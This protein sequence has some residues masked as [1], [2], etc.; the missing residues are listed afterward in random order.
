MREILQTVAKVSRSM[1]TV[2]LRGESGTGKGLL[3]KA[4]HQQSPR[5]LG[6]FITV[7]CAAIPEGIIE[8]ELFGHEKGA[9]TGALR[10]REGRFEQAQG[11]TIF[12]DE[13]GDLPPLMQVRLL[14]VLQERTFERVGGNEP[15]K[16]DVRVIA[17]THRDLE[18]G[19]EEGAFRDDLY[20]RLNVVPI[21]LPPLRERKE[22]LPLLIDY[23]LER[24]NLENQKRVR[25]SPELRDLMRRYDW[26]GNIR[27][28]QNCI[29][30]I[31][32]LA[33]EE[34]VGLKEIPSPI[35]AYFQD[36][37]QVASS[38]AAGSLKDNLATL[39]RERILAA[40][41]KSAWVQAKAARLLGITPRQIAYKIMKYRLQPPGDV[42]TAVR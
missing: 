2:L 7:N 36:M 12:L 3:A 18:R 34:F 25:L 11:G 33:E 1:A 4:I 14:R 23:F 6:R 8:S 21:F 10:K 27:E 41:E 16:S 35:Q 38:R 37:R 42:E 28:L 20:W 39:E 22:D 26:P 19:I 5:A 15:I 24:Y 29:E 32:V 40:L 17:A 13:V 9:F 31:V 30:R